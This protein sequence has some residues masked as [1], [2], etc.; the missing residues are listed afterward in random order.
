[1]KTRF[2]APLLT[3]LGSFSAAMPAAAQQWPTKPL[4][5]IVPFPPGGASM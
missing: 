5:I 3:L 2:T 4:R 1:M